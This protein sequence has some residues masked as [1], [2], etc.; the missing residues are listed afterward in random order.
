MN[1]PNAFPGIIGAIDC[2]HVQIISPP[3]HDEQFPAI[4]FLNR[5]GT[6]SL[7]VQIVI[8]FQ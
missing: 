6:H 8:K 7:N 5:K 4:I 1:M 3:V 2:T